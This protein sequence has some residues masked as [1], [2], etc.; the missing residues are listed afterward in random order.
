MT[1][2][3]VRKHT[4][5]RMAFKGTIALFAVKEYWHKK[6]QKLNGPL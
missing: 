1:Q 5:Q 6:L 3:R 2:T 4:K